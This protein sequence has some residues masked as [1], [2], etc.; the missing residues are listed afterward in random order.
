MPRNLLA[1]RIMQRIEC[2]QIKL[3]KDDVRYGIIITG[4]GLDKSHGFVEPYGG[5]Q[6]IER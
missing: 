5:L 1:L 6:A 3:P 4:L 2:G